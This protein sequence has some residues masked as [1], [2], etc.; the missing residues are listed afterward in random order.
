MIKVVKGDLKKVSGKSIDSYKGYTMQWTVCD[1]V[2]RMVC[3]IV[4]SISSAHD[5]EY[6][7]GKP[8]YVE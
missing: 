1:M 4:E 8:R 2:F 3:D 5:A 7:V 6:D